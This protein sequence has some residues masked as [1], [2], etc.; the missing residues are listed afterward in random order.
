MNRFVHRIIKSSTAS[1]ITSG[2]HV[3]TAPK[4]AVQQLVH[5]ELQHAKLLY[6][7]EFHSES[8][9]VAFQTEL[10]REWSKCLAS[11]G[12][13]SDAQN[14][15]RDEPLPRLHLIME[16]FSVDMQPMLERYMGVDNDDGNGQRTP[17]SEEDD[18]AFEELLTSY[19]NDYGTEGHDLKPY[20]NLLQFCRQTNKRETNSPLEN[21]VQQSFCEVSIHGGF[22]PRNHASRLNKECT[23]ISSKSAFFDDMSSSQRAYL[24]K[25]GDA[26]RNALFEDP[27]SFKLRGSTEHRLLIQSL[28]R[29]T[30]LYSPPLEAAAEEAANGVE[31]EETPMSRLY[32]AQLLKD[33]A[34]G[35]R[36]SVV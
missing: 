13:S 25:E 4:I 6:F 14:E 21:N 36:K 18:T 24:P 31:E 28:M 27:P 33:H 3:T 20:R 32:Q 29:G 9:I 17:F 34:M 1:S 15:P 19:K 26:M 5:H 11:V 22:I 23:D 35:D 7:G 8:R 12:S 10:I 2:P 16:H 30:D